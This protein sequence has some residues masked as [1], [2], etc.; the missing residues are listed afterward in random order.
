MEIYGVGISNFVIRRTNKRKRQDINVG[1]GIS[2]K[3][4]SLDNEE[5]AHVSSLIKFEATQEFV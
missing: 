5:N 3:V 2:H 4:S 1:A